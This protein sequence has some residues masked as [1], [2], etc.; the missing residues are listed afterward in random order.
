MTGV[1]SGATGTVYSSI[2]HTT[3]QGYIA[4]TGVSGTFGT[5]E[6][7]RVSG[8]TF[9]TSASAATAYVPPTGFYRWRNYNFYATSSTYYT[10]GVNGSGPA[11][12][13]DQNNVVMPI[14]FPLNPLTGQPSANNP[15]LL[16]VYANSLFLA[17]PGGIYQ[18]SV[19]G[20]PTQYNGFLGA[21]QFSTGAEL[22]GL[23]SIAGPNLALLTNRNTQV[24][25]GNTTATYVQ[26]MAA[27][28]AGSIK[29]ASQLLDTVYAIN[30]LGITSLSRTQSYG[31]FVG[32]TVSQL[33][34]PI[35]NPLK[36]YFADATVVRVANQCRFYFSDGSVIIMYIPGLGQ[37][38]KAWAATES[39]VTA[40][41]GYAS[42]PAPVYCI[43]DSE[44]AS[45]NEV[46]YFGSSNGDGY[47]YQD[48]SGTSFDG[49]VITSYLRTAFNNVGTPALRKYFRRADIEINSPAQIYLQFAADLSYSSSQNSSAV[50]QL[51]SASQI[52]TLQVFGGGG[53]WDTVNWNQFQWDGQSISSARANLSG[54]GENVSFLIFHQ[55]IVD[56][57]FVLQGVII[58]YDPRR[59]TR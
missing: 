21:A 1:T 30:N 27:E 17:L 2:S 31:N 55:A 14:L 56:Q 40:Q 52:A 33:I 9:G 6:G 58:Y 11:F 18:A 12:Q 47:V 42:Y 24:L 8:T 38:N 41:F 26:S 44:D 16:E 50:S 49:A 4:M 15:F 25:G 20:S 51:V 10:Y 54:T 34:Q 35:L 5:S 13:I 59:L 19:P 29:F 53:Y 36:P 23:F 22:T 48:R 43:S 3:T 57:P 45:N 28:K 37:Q 32:S 7:L 39:G 46:S